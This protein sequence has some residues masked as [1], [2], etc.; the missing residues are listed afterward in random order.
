MLETVKKKQKDKRPLMS[1]EHLVKCIKENDFTYWFNRVS[2]K[3]A[4]EQLQAKYGQRVGRKRLKDV[5]ESNCKWWKTRK[6]YAEAR[7][8]LL[9]GDQWNQLR[10][11]VLRHKEEIKNMPVEHAS[12]IIC[13]WYRTNSA[14]L[15]SLMSDLHFWKQSN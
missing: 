10:Q 11:A 1:V 6:R 7:G 15:N 4:T 14:Q 3:E 5:I 12:A 8:N 2:M 9:S 13:Q